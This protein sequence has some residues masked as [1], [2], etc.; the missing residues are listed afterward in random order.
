MRADRPSHT[1]QRVALSRAAHQLYD[2]P[3]ILE[4]PIA[5]RII[6][7]QSEQEVRAHRQRFDTRFARHL[8]AFLVARSRLAEDALGAAVARGVG[9]YVILGAGLDTFAYRNPYPAA[10]LRVFEVDHPATQAWKR[11]QL[12]AADIGVPPSLTLVPVDFETERLA[13]ALRGAGLR[14]A[15][16]AFFSWLGVTMYLT[17]A[18]VLATLEF[19]AG[20]NARGSGIVFDYVTSLEGLSFTRR[21]LARALLR[22]V[23]ALGEPW[24]SCFDPRALA[25][26][27][28]ALGFT[29]TE[30]FG[31][32]ELNARFFSERHD[33]LRVAGPGRV[34]S[35][36]L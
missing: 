29:Q 16:P 14:T 5:L 11:R 19:V 21:L 17:R 6:G 35:A 20:A 15:Q 27:L 18:A 9:Q 24:Q 36:Q 34:L 22:R 33:R 28:R 26:E 1:A 30:D 12:S 4:D 2:R 10:R 3:K 13:D 31:P 8:R 32:A 7:T 25:G 23:A